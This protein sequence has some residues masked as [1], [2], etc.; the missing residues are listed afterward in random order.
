[1]I[2][3][4]KKIK[5]SRKRKGS[6]TVEATLIFPLIMFVMFGI[7]YLTIIHYQNNVMI[8]ESIR[9][10]NRAGAYWQYIDMG[11]TEKKNLLGDIERKVDYINYDDNHIPYPFDSSVPM[12]G[13]I[14]IEMI[15]KRNPYRSI[16]DLIANVLSEPFGIP[17][18]KKSNAEQYVNSRI[19][20]VKYKSNEES[21]KVGKVGKYIDENGKEIDGGIKNGGYM[22]FG[23]DLKINVGR[24]YINPLANLSKRFFKGNDVIDKAMRK[25]IVVSGVISNQ[26]EFIRNLDTIYDMGVNIYNLVMPE[27]GN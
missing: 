7:I 20:N 15:K 12:N 4:I 1:M 21:T 2:N 22:F 23:D 10:M 18:R 13:I 19:A 8:A 26:A 17:N 14:N 24:S 16:I 27:D 25:D 11:M 3:L 5:L 9:A 6:T